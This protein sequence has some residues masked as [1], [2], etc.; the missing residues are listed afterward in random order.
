MKTYSPKPQDI[1]R[2]WYV[3]DA[4]GAVL[5]RLSSE[6]AAIL[7]GKHKPIFAPHADTGDHVIVINAGLVHLTGRKEGGKLYRSHSGFMGGLKTAA[8]GDVRKQHP[9]RLV[10]EAVRGMLPKTKLG[11]AMF[12]KLKVYAGDTHPHQA[13]KPVAVNVK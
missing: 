2:R 12:G 6:V 10:E 13:Q 8:A 3:I 5:G 7:R 9:T 1:E 4:S 11:K